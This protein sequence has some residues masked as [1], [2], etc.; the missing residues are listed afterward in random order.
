MQA[1]HKGNF[2]TISRDVGSAWKNNIDKYKSAKWHKM[3][4]DEKKV[5]A[6]SLSFVKLV[7][8]N[9]PFF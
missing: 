5:F 4:L 3:S 6:S 2:A 7:S 8:P 9:P 1:R